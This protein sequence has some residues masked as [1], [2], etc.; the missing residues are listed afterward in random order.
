[1]TE[2]FQLCEWGLSSWKTASLFRNNIW[3]MGC[4]WLPNLS[5]YSLVVIR[6]W[7]VIMGPTKYRTTIPLPKPSE[8]LSRVSTVGTRHS[9]L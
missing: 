3:I 1:M 8:N 7:R 2:Q 6:P 5:M 9:G 4:T